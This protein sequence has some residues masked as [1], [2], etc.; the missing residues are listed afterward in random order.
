MGVSLYYGYGV[1]AVLS[2]HEE[3]GLL[4]WQ[5]LFYSVKRNVAAPFFHLARADKVS[6]MDPFICLIFEDEYSDISRRPNNSCTVTQNFNH[7]HLL[8][9]SRSVT[10]NVAAAAVYNGLRIQMTWCHTHASSQPKIYCR[11]EDRKNKPLQLYWK[12]DSSSEFP[13]SLR[14]T[15]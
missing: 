11:M 6:A 14:P 8:P 3:E 13:H 7:F 4:T 2:C 9:C 10:A 12:D 15:T 1:Q 5:I